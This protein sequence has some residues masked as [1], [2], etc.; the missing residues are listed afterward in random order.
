MNTGHERRRDASRTFPSLGLQEPR[1]NDSGFYGRILMRAKVSDLEPR[2]NAL[3]G[4]STCS[5]WLG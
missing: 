2:V 3:K 1:V 5:T 4:A